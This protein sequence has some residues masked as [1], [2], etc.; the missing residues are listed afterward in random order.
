MNG[1]K[2]C[3]QGKFSIYLTYKKSPLSHEVIFYSASVRYKPSQVK[4]QLEI[5]PSLC[6]VGFP[7]RS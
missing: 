5:S 2:N 4:D 1:W 3:L 6:T 7:L